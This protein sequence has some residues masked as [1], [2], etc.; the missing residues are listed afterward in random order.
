ML[1]KLEKVAKKVKASLADII[2]LG[3][4]VGLEKSIK[5]AGFKV[6]VKIYH[7]S[8]FHNELHDAFYCAI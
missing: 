5:K 3:G 4:N 7:L 8:R 2:I 6:N 1:G